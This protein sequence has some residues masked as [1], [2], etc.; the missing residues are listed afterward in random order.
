M[1]GTGRASPPF[2]TLLHKMCANETFLGKLVCNGEH[3]PPG[4][5][6]KWCMWGS[7]PELV[8]HQV[9]QGRQRFCLHRSISILAKFLPRQNNADHI[10]GSGSQTG[11][12]KRQ[13]RSSFLSLM[14][15]CFST[16]LNMYSTQSTFKTQKRL[17]LNFSLQCFTL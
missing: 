11:S 2:T 17:Q 15:Q 12:S 14:Q 7:G 5:E 3:S 1:A 8:P 6:L 10:M 9:S 13:N 16:K 4:A